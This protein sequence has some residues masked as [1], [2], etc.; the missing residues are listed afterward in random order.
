M[1]NWGDGVRGLKWLAER[2]PI[3]Y[4]SSLTCPFPKL[5]H[6]SLKNSFDHLQDCHRAFGYSQPNFSTNFWSILTIQRESIETTLPR[7]TGKKD[8]ID[9]YIFLIWSGSFIFYFVVWNH[10]AHLP[11][12][13]TLL[14]PPS[15]VCNQCCCSK[16]TCEKIFP[17]AIL[18]KQSKS[19]SGFQTKQAVLPW[20]LVEEPDMSQAEK[21]SKHYLFFQ[22]TLPRSCCAQCFHLSLMKPKYIP[23]AL[24]KISHKVTA[25]LR[26]SQ[27]P[28]LTLRCA[29]GG[30][31]CSL[32]PQ[33]SWNCHY[34]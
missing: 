8:N 24:C 18:W 30:R 31:A 27:W 16:P 13:T 32:L 19:L 29:G 15:F 20:P 21:G 4:S 28:L 9:I 6:P 10:N 3:Y 12:H 26:C 34:G 23:D 25:K 5:F 22:T 2:H 33:L 7:W 11:F 14:S 1:I 17:K